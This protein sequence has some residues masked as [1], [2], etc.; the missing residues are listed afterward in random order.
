VHKAMLLVLCDMQG[1]AFCTISKV[2]RDFVPD[3]VPE[4]KVRPGPQADQPSSVC[5]YNRPPACTS[6]QLMGVSL[7]NRARLLAAPVRQ[8]L[9]LVIAHQVATRT[10]HPHGPCRP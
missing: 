10:S 4:A 9:P 7:T 1:A 3:P 2:G 8:A 5:S 6:V